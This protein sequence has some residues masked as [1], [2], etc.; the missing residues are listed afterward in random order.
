MLKATQSLVRRFHL[1]A[2][3][4]QQRAFEARNRRVRDEHFASARWWFKLA[5]SFDFAI[6]LTPLDAPQLP[7]EPIPRHPACPGCIEPMRLVEFSLLRDNWSAVSNA[8]LAEKRSRLHELIMKLPRKWSDIPF[9]HFGGISDRDRAGSG[10][11]SPD[12]VWFCNR[13]G[14]ELVWLIVFALAID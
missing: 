5:E 6:R 11:S 10:N 4:E 12:P 8:T 13:D 7:D 1:H 9:W 3:E 2:L 14:S